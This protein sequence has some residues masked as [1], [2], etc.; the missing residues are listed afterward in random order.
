[1]S[2]PIKLV[3]ENINFVYSVLLYIKLK[4]SIK[5]FFYKFILD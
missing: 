2:I 3:G 1:M 4:Q 5:G